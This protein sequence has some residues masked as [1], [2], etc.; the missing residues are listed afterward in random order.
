M[1]LIRDCNDSFSLSLF[2]LPIA[3]DRKSEGNV[4]FKGLPSSGD[5]GAPAISQ[6]K[7]VTEIFFL[8]QRALHVGVIPA[9]NAYSTIVSDLAKEVQSGNA[10]ERIKVLMTVR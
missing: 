2:I 9:M 6:F 1:F 3:R 8:A 7:F 10:D 4:R 5:T